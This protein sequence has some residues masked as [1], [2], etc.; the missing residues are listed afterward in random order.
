[1]S[2]STPTRPAPARAI[3]RSRW[4]SRPARPATGSRS[5]PPKNGSTAS[6]RP[7]TA[8]PSTPNSDGWSAYS[9]LVVDE[10]G[11][12]PLER[13]A[14]NLLF[15]LVAR[16]YERGSIY[17]HQQPAASK[18]GARSSATRWSPPHSSTGSSTTLTSSPS[19]ARATGSERG[20]PPPRRRP[21]SSP[22]AYGRRP[23]SRPP[24]HPPAH[25]WLP[26]TCALFDSC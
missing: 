6:S 14:A 20:E 19:K 22:P 11:Y 7:S 15:A 18:P 2:S 25:Y 9:L 4:R 21:R 3:W 17:R 23:E 1:M 13:Q 24:D 8:T 12:L 10:I 16:R 26:D 5:R